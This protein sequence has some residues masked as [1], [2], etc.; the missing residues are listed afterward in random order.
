MQCR[1]AAALT[2]KFE[3]PARD[4]FE[5]TAGAVGRLGLLGGGFIIS[6]KFFG[7]CFYLLPFLFFFLLN[8]SNFHRP[9][10]LVVTK[11]SN[12]TTTTTTNPLG[13]SFALI[14]V[15]VKIIK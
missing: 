8:L 13:F 2:A 1:W 14:I 4:V 11:V 5:L 9:E 12:D 10:M 6:Q 7:L 3:T 15:Q